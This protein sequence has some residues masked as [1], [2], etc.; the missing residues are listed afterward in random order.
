MD[1]VGAD[2]RSFVTI[3][4]GAIF[5]SMKLFIPCWVFN[6]SSASLKKSSLHPCLHGR[7]KAVGL[8]GESIVVVKINWLC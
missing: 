1:M 7:V 3:R 2:T 8:D 5:C 4:P 6:G